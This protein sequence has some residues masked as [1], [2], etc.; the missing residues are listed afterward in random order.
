MREILFKARRVDN[1]EWVE[2]YVVVYPSGKTEIRKRCTE[3]PDVLLICEVDPETVCQFTGL[4]DMN[5]KK[6]WEHDI[7]RCGVNITVIW[8]KEY[9]GWCLGKDDWMYNHFFGESA[10]PEKCEVVGNIFDNPELISN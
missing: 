1:G 3:S 5:D 2:G 4:T 6:I 9:A 8:S 7:V 10:E